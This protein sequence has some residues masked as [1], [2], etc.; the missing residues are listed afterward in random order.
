M[1]TMDMLM[2]GN[3][4]SRMTGTLMEEMP[5]N[6]TRSV[7]VP[8][9]RPVTFVSTYFSFRPVLFK[10]N[11]NTSASTKE[12]VNSGKDTPNLS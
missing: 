12:M 10:I 9:I 4:Y 11:E 8:E 3:A 5:K 2:S 1:P 6:T 7:Q